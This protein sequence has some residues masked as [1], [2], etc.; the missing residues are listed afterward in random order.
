VAKLETRTMAHDI[1]M[2]KVKTEYEDELEARDEA[3]DKAMSTVKMEYEDKLEAR[4]K[5][6]QIVLSEAK[7]EHKGALKIRDER[8]TSVAEL[9]RLHKIELA[10]A[11]DYS[12]AR[13]GTMI[14]R[15]IRLWSCR[16]P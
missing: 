7:R 15:P 6:H 9:K 13:N 4:D 5:E 2:N 3:H 16:K 10:T 1:A 12:A 14:R 11:K 8:H